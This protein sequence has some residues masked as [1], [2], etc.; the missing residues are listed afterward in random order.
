MGWGT[1]EIKLRSLGSADAPI[2]QL[3]AVD[4]LMDQPCGATD[5]G[6]H[7]DGGSARGGCRAGGLGSASNC[8]RRALG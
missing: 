5:P 6:A 4:A 1:A 3:Y 8:S 7:F 2:M